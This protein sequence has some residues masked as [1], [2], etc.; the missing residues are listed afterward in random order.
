[1]SDIYLANLIEYRDKLI[2][3]QLELYAELREVET[4]LTRVRKEI[5]EKRPD[6]KPNHRWPDYELED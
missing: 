2:S 6:P 3:R 4:L 1:M 5:Q